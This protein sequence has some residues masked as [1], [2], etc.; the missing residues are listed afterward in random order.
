[1]KALLVVLLIGL[2][3]LC[4]QPTANELGAFLGL[5]ANTSVG[6][7]DIEPKKDGPFGEVIWLKAY[8]PAESLYRYVIGMSKRG[9]LFRGNR[10]QIEQDIGN[11]PNDLR[12]MNPSSFLYKEA[13]HTEYGEAFFTIDSA[14]KDA[15]SMIG[16]MTAGDYDFFVIEYALSISKWRESNPDRNPLTPKNRLPDVLS[17]IVKEAQKNEPKQTTEPNKALEPTIMAVTPPAAQESRR[18]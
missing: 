14:T 5:P 12:R 3:P 8:V 15:T 11:R 17:F 2:A 10:S 1:M 9:T 7:Q 6:T 4:A 18:P 16:F 13:M